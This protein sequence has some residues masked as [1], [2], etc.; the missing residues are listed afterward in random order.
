MSRYLLYYKYIV[1][2]QMLLKNPEIK[3]YYLYE[4]DLKKI[5]FNMY[6]NNYYK[7]SYLYLYNI[8]LLL[9]IL[10]GKKISIKKLTQDYKLDKIHLQISLKGDIMYD[11]ID[12]FTTILLP[13]FQ[14]YSMLLSLHH[15]D[16][17]GN[18]IY[19]FQYVDPI[20]TS[21]NIVTIWSPNNKVTI[22]FILKNREVNMG[23]LL[24]YLK[25]KW[26]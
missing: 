3:K 4:S 5:I 14:Q 25:L 21:K 9:L 20:F 10:T 12:M 26:F 7:Y 24:Q 2:P 19:R 16:T 1:R 22:L 8:F 18:F 23:I 11:F 17:F 15:Y 13:L 6:V